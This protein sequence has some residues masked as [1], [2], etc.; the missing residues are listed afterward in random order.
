MK[1][2]FLQFVWTPY[3]GVIG[4]LSQDWLCDTYVIFWDIAE[5]CLPS[6]VM[7]KFR[8]LQTVPNMRDEKQHKY[9]HNLTRRGS[10]SRDWR[11]LLEP[12]ILNWNSRRTHPVNGD[13]SHDPRT[14]DEYMGWYWPR[15]VLYI[16]NPRSGVENS[17]RSHNHGGTI[18]I[19]VRV[20]I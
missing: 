7:R 8:L 3:D 1:V 4:G 17:F 18:E 16:T 6:R 9:L 19:V 20:Y 10:S 13:F 2:I 5:E 14:V 15:T 11:R 12:Q